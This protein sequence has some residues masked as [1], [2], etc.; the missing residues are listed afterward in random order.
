VTGEPIDVLIVAS[1]FPAYDDPAK[2]RF[3]ADQAEALALTGLARPLVISF[4]P[5]VLSGGARARR[6]QEAA[7]TA[8]ARRAATDAS[9]FAIADGVRGGVRVAR[10]TIAEGRTSSA[11]PTHAARHRAD[12]LAAFGDS[13]AGDGTT[14]Q[15]G[16]VHAHV[17]YPDGAAAVALADRLGWP[18]IVTEHSSAVARITAEPA[19]REA[20]AATLARAYRTL[21]VSETLAAELRAAF[22]E[23]AANVEVMPNAVAVDEFGPPSASDRVPD[24]LLFVGYLKESK[25][26]ETLLRATAVARSLRPSVTLRLIG[27][28][29]EPATDARWRRLIADLGLDDAVTIEGTA[30]RRGIAAA[31]GQ[32]ALFVHPSPRETFG[33]VAVEAL[34]SGLPVVA[35]DSGGVTEILG[36]EPE[37]VG[38]I[39][40]VGDPQA[41]GEAIV[42]TLGRLDGFDRDE[43][44]RSVERRYGGSYVAERLAVVYREAI[45]AT[46]SGRGLVV[47]DVGGGR[48]ERTIVVALDRRRAAPRLAPL[49]LE[50]RKRIVVVTATE[51][52]DVKLPPVG[53]VVEVEV[54]TG[55]GPGPSAPR[56]TRRPGAAGRLARLAHDP[57]GTVRRVLGRDAGTEHALAEAS[58]AVAA[59]ARE[60]ARD[61]RIEIIGVDGHDHLAAAEALRGGVAR[62]A[63]GGLR[64]LVDRWAAGRVDDPGRVDERSP[65]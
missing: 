53:R 28:A 56:S 12:A 11:G 52:R 30:D 10:P 4:D 31:M 18:L 34:A 45:A 37:R 21:A 19:I 65:T 50:L 1:W 46:P 40:A 43:M 20:Y 17:V 60:E 23:S 9:T 8:A 22:P 41:L 57:V 59:V 47:E 61:G 24:Q 15:T 39:V 64:V 13:R 35:T 32:A 44:R 6:Q 55:W 16:V 7:V 27:R 62:P 51:P 25:G 49:P 29:P 38:A 58:R 42:A 48:A 63:A 2:G 36:E 14:D 33:V 5:A 54:D 3:V 26:I